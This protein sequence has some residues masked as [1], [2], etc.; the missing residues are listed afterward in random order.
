MAF[1]IEDDGPLLERLEHLREAYKLVS[2]PS[3]TKDHYRMGD[4][5][6]VAIRLGVEEMEKLVRERQ[7]ATSSTG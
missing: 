5:A 4:I 1:K 3:G 2:P 7:L 6:R